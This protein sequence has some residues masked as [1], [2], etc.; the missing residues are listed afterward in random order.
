MTYLEIMDCELINIAQR[1]AIEGKIESIKPLGDGFINDTFIV[2]TTG[3]GPDYI[4]QRKNH[5]VFPHVP[6]MMDNIVKVTAH[7]KAK[8]IHAGGDPMRLSDY[9]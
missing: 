1:F 8:I 3:E 7:I 5:K 4:L 6:E 9:C 2:K